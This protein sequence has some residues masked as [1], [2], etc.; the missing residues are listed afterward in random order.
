MAGEKRV[1]RFPGPD[2]RGQ[3]V[4]DARFDFRIDG[5]CDLRDQRH[6][7][8]AERTINEWLLAVGRGLHHLIPDAAESQAQIEPGFGNV[9]HQR[10]GERTVVA[11]AVTGHRAGLGGVGDQRVRH[12]R[13]DLREPAPDRAAGDAALHRLGERIV[14][15][16]VQ[17][18]ELEALDRIERLEHAIERHGFVL[19]VEIAQQ[20]RVRG[21]Q[22]IGAV[23]LDAVTRIIDHR[24][25]GIAGNLGEF[26]DRAAQVGNAE[27]TPAVD[28]VEAGLLEQCGHGVGVARRVGEP[29]HLLISG[30][31]DHQRDALVRQRLSSRKAEQ[32]GEENQEYE[33]HSRRP[34]AQ[35]LN[36]TN[37]PLDRQVAGRGDWNCRSEY[38]FP[39]T[40]SVSRITDAGRC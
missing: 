33:P 31:A 13:F 27:V 4:I 24:D 32:K 17:D 1:P 22:I 6:G 3:L 5:F 18:H 26:A 36:H 16:S 15:A 8:A 30:H 38:Q 29:R 9:F 20:P 39:A 14:A 7:L 19:D 28:R 10:G 11:V 37:Q 35:L 12:R 23:D 34:T 25:I 40:C 21:H 2:L